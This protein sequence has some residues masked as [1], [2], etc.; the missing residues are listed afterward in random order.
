MKVKAKKIIP[1][2]SIIIEGLLSK[3]IEKG[4]LSPESVIIHEAVVA[5]LEAQA[6]RNR[7][8]G[9]LGLEEIKKLREM[10]DKKKFV[11]SFKGFWE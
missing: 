10:A 3:K 2:T 8:V 1:D 7:E 11:L 4:E 5:E 6:N 9:Y